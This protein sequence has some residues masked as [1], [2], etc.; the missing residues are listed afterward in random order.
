MKDDLL[1]EYRLKHDGTLVPVAAALEDLIK[2][3]LDNVTHID[4]V[5]A[6]AK[7]PGRFLTKARKLNSAGGLRYP[8]PLVQIQDLIGARVIV[9][10]KSDVAIVEE[11]LLQYFT[12]IESRTIVPDSEWEFGYFGR[13]FIMTLP[14]DAVPKEVNADET[15]GFFELQ[16]KTLFQ[17]A[18][19]EAE[20][21]LGYKPLEELSAD[22]K[23]LLAYTSAQAWGADDVFER[24][25]VQ[26]KSG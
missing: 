20:H 18:W 2:D 5:S 12:P 26:L 19:S 14:R 9:F 1:A 24:L 23:R 17:H 21:D 13:H 6:R 16:L 3:H 25:A 4:R 10:Y 8:E 15:P 11:L 7:S 22:Q